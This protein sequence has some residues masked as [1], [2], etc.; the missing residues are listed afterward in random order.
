MFDDSPAYVTGVRRPPS[1]RWEQVKHDLHRA[2]KAPK[3]RTGRALDPDDV[4]LAQVHDYLLKKGVEKFESRRLARLFPEL[5][6]ADCIREEQEATTRWMLEALVLADVPVPEIAEYLATTEDVVRMYENVFFDVRSR[7]KSRGFING[8]LIGQANMHPTKEDPDKYWKMLA[9]AGGA[10]MLYGYWDH[11][12]LPVDVANL[13]RDVVRG[14][15][16]HNAVDVAYCM[17][18]TRDNATQIAALHNDDRK[19]ELL[20]EQARGAR[21][22]DTEQ[23]KALVASLG[24]AVAG[25]HSLMSPANHQARLV[26]PR[27]DEQLKQQL[28]LVTMEQDEAPGPSTKDKQ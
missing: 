5:Y 28:A 2:P 6:E 3:K 7:L 4:L 18:L 17:P 26:E 10:P 8:V 21:G 16:I 1:W 12:V 20:L 15:T 23:T 9:M 11:G 19:L 13:M 22:D 14:R 24:F 25:I 27:A